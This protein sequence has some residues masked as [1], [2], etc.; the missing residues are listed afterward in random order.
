MFNG[1]NQGSYVTVAAPGV[2]ILV[3]A[4]D[5]G[6]QF[7][8][9]TSV[10]TANVS[11]VAALL[12]AHKPS[13]TYGGDPRSSGEDRQASR[14]PRHQSAISARA[15]VD[16][17]KALETEVSQAPRCSSYAQQ[18]NVRGATPDAQ[19]PAQQDAQQGAAGRCQQLPRA[20]PRWQQATRCGW[21]LRARLCGRRRLVDQGGSPARCRPQV[22]HRWLSFGS[23]CAA[24]TS[25]ATPSAA[26]S[27]AS[28]STRWP[29][30]R[31]GVTP[32]F[33]VGVLG[34]YEH[35][36]YSSQAFQRRAGEE[37]AGTTG[38]YMGWRIL[39]NVRFDAGGAWSD[40]FV[41]DT[42]GMA[43]GNF[44][45]HRWLVTGG[46]TGTYDWRA[47]V[48]EPSARVYALWEHEN[49][50]TDSL[51]TLQARP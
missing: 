26:I 6:I 34:G 22:I 12:I 50:Y 42:S 29:A 17:L 16:P 5:G 23:T 48:L 28:R 11:G 15:S 10:A 33:L 37:M 3:P 4:P 13:L 25:I 20:S 31:T 46:L 30:S 41:D 21:L 49:A 44:L 19:P 32:D 38:A 7:T 35:F 43:T 36:D 47:F 14:L 8:T 18:N 45:G 1:A 39:P 51:G 9:G 27:R 40:I 24:Q 2:N